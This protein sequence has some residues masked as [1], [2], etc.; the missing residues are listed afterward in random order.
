MK[1][2][3]I[4]SFQW[5]LVATAYRFKAGFAPKSLGIL[6]TRS[7]LDNFTQLKLLYVR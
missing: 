5:R 6:S 7:I 1:C 4:A 3:K 2:V